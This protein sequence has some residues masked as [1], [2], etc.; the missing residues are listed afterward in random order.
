MS[1]IKHPNEIDVL[2]NKGEITLNESTELREKWNNLTEEEKKN[3]KHFEIFKDDKGTNNIYKMT[4][5]Q[6]LRSIAQN[7]RTSIKLQKSIKLWVTFFGIM[8]ILSLLGYIL[9]NITS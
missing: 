7:M 3:Y 8:Y 1:D 2:Y 9:I 5:I 6:V 4:E